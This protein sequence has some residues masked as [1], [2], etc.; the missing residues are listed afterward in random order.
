MKC[1]PFDPD[2]SH[3]AVQNAGVECQPATGD[4]DFVRLSEL[5]HV[6]EHHAEARG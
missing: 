1:A 4:H 6:V 2:I 3:E 5:R